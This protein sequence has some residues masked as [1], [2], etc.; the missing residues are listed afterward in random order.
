MIKFGRVKRGSETTLQD[1]LEHLVWTSAHG[2]RYDEECERPIVSTDEVTGEIV[3]HELIVPVIT[4]RLEGGDV[5]GTAWYLH[6]DRM[7]FAIA[8]WV[9]GRWAMLDAVPDLPLPTIFVAVPPI[10]GR[11]G[12]RFLREPP[13]SERATRMD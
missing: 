10:L 2:G 12:V 1:H 11:A 3:D 5:H 8:L 4:I 9:D 13:P 6:K 7:I